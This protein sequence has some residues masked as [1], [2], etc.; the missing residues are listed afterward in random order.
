MYYGAPTTKV[1]SMDQDI[2]LRQRK[3]LGVSVRNTHKSR[4]ASTRMWRNIVSVI[5]VYNDCRV[6][7]VAVSWIR[8]LE[9]RVFTGTKRRH[10]GVGYPHT[11]GGGGYLRSR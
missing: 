9:D 1:A 8:G 7:H 4:P 11:R 6:G 2:T 5:V 3:R 10:D